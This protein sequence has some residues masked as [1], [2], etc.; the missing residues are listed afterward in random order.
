MEI[1][2]ATAQKTQEGLPVRQQAF[3]VVRR[4][5]NGTKRGKVIAVP[6][7]HTYHAQEVG[8]LSPSMI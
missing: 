5:I 1:Q 2:E 4:G 7:V 8:R 6:E 3:R